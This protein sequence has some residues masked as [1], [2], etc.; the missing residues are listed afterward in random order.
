MDSTE[1][2]LEEET[3]KWLFKLEK[4]IPLIKSTGNI[5]EKIVNESLE[6]INAYISDCKYFQGED[7]WIRAFESIV[8]AWGIYETMV[9]LGAIDLK[10]D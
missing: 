8:Y 6:N 10:E 9:R 5:G 1:E 7:D 3:K 2:Q 4:E